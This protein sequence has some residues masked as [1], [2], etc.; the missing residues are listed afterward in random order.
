MHASKLFFSLQNY[1]VVSSIGGIDITTF[2]LHI[3]YIDIDIVLILK[4]ISKKTKTTTKT[5]QTTRN[6]KR[7]EVTSDLNS[8][9]LFKIEQIVNLSEELP[10]NT[11]DMEAAAKKK[12][13][14]TGL[15]PKRELKYYQRPCTSRT[16]RHV[17]VSFSSSSSTRSLVFGA[18]I[19]L[20][21]VF[22]IASDKLCRTIFCCLSV[23][24][25]SVTP[26]QIFT[27]LW[28]I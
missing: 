5:W 26:D 20:I 3:D 9:S 8:Q 19:L 4:L 12:K 18:V 10:P 14:K 17:D 21:S 7:M 13:K 23:C 28:D 1:P 16:E 27:F 15:M 11:R 6:S 25:G 22:G 2:R 24:K